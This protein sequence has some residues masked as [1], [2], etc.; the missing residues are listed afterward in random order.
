[1]TA[2]QDLKV[3]WKNVPTHEH[4][5]RLALVAKEVVDLGEHET[6]HIAGACLVN[7]ISEESVAWRSLDEIVDERS[8]VADERSRATGWH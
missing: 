4:L 8:G 5:H 1:M 2:S 7:R 6:R 3:T